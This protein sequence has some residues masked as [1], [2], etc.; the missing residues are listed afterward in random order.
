MMGLDFANKSSTMHV[1]HCSRN[2]MSME[3]QI[4]GDALKPFDVPLTFKSVVSL[5]RMVPMVHYINY[6][7]CFKFKILNCSKKYDSHILKTGLDFATKITVSMS[8]I[9]VNMDIYMNFLIAL[10]LW[11][12]V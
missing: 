2:E 9:S 11:V 4:M 3:P 6:Y 7:W 8:S 1:S 12:D 10:I 5:L